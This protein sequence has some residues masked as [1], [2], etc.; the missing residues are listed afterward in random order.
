MKLAKNIAEFE[1]PIEGKSTFKEEFVTCGGIPLKQ[2]NMKSMESK[3]CNGLF[4][5]G[6]I[7]DVDGV[8]GGFNFMNCWST[9]YVSG[10]AAVQHVIKQH[11]HASLP[12]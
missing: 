3:I 11:D 10:N 9:G 8:T 4:F 12:T 2:I 6:E 7:I 5:C 1:I